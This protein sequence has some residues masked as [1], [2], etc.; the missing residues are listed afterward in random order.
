MGQGGGKKM[1]ILNDETQMH[2]FCFLS[3]GFVWF[4]VWFLLFLLFFG[5]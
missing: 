1:I 4:V 2:V 3:Y 5:G